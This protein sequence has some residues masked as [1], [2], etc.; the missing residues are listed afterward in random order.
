M[1]WI[2]ARIATLILEKMDHLKDLKFFFNKLNEHTSG[3]ADIKFNLNYIFKILFKNQ[4][5]NAVK[6]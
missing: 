2:I 4:E 3:E 5:V 1:K 6:L